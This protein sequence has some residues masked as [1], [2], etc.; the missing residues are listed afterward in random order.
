MG[1]IAGLLRRANG[2]ND[3]VRLRLQ[4]IRMGLIE[5]EHDAGNE[6]A[7]TVLAGPH[8]AHTIRVDCDI[9]R[10]VVT[11]GIG[12]VEQNPGGMIRCFNRGLHRSAE[13]DLHAQV[14]AFSRRRYPLHRC[15]P[16]A[17]RCGGTRQQEHQ[18]PN[19]FLN[20]HHPLLTLAGAPPAA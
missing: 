2:K 20:C 10:T 14:G 19:M 8:P 18:A 12:E 7:G 6:R 16:G 9:L 5:I 11:G 13:R 4:R 3:P 1:N 15:R 17:L